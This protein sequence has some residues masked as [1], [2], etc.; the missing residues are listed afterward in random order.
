[1]GR[2]GQPAGTTHATAVASAPDAAGA[3]QTGPPGRSSSSLHYTQVQPAEALRGLQCC[4]TQHAHLSR[5]RGQPCWLITLARQTSHDAAMM[6][7]MPAAGMRRAGHAWCVLKQEPPQRT[8][9]RIALH[10]YSPAACALQ[11]DTLHVAAAGCCC[12]AVVL[13]CCGAVVLWCCGAVRCERC[14]GWCRW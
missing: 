2:D 11:Q 6:P 10:T 14:V 5:Q 4:L 1:M 8:A 13:W 3:E 12:G 7:A 9:A